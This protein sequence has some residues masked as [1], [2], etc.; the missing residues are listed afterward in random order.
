VVL[1]G[2]DKEILD[3]CNIEL[4]LGLSK[5]PDFVAKTNAKYVVGEA[6]FLS[7]SGGNQSRGLDDAL[8]LASNTSGKAYKAAVVDGVVWIKPG[9]QGYKKI[10]NASVTVFSAL[11]LERF[12]K[13]VD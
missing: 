8:K 4:S 13:E 3:F 12:L 9:S 2:T 5:R 10:E 1:D 11:L 6:K 7:S